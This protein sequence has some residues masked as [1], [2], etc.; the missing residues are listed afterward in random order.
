MLYLSRKGLSG[1][2]IHSVIVYTLGPDAVG[3]STVTLYLRDGHCIGPMD[4]EAAPDH[5]DEP[6]DSDQ[7]MLTV[8]SE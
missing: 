3:Y 1:K 6:G 7:V 4:S 8:L 5:H 2:D